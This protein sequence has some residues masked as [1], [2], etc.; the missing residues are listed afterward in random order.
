MPQKDLRYLIGKAL[1]DDDFKAQ[2]LDDPE[3]T[4]QSEGCTI[5]PQQANALRKMT[6]D[7]WNRIETVLFDTMLATS[8]CSA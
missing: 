4:A 2:L 3:A 6:P 5:T 7:D 8:P 1:T